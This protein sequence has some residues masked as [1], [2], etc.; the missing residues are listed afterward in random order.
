MSMRGSVMASEVLKN[1]LLIEF[2]SVRS[3]SLH[4]LLGVSELEITHRIYR[5]EL[6]ISLLAMSCLLWGH[7]RHHI[8]VMIQTLG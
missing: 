6:N 8:Q 1:S 4:L 3:A 5:D 2:Q 7:V